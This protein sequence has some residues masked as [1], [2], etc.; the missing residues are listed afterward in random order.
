MADTKK[1]LDSEGLKL[2]KADY[3]GKIGKKVDAVSGK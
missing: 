2:V 1:F 3:D